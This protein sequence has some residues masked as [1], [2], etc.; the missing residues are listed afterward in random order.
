MKNQLPAHALILLIVCLLFPH[1]ALA[2]GPVTLDQLL[3]EADRNNPSLAAAQEQIAGAETKVAQVTSLADPVLSVALSNYPIDSLKSNQTPMTGNEIRLAQKFPFPGKL[4]AGGK[5]AAQRI[6]WYASAYQDARLQ[7]RQKV[8]DAWFRLL[9]LRQAI[10]LAQSN[11]G[12]IDDFIQ[13]TETRYQVGKGLQQNVLKANLQRSKQLDMLFALQQQEQATLG[14]INSLVGRGTAT[15]I[16]T[17]TE[18]KPQGVPF[19]LSQLQQQA[20]QKRPMFTA[21][22]AMIEEAKAKR[23]QARLGYKPDFTVWGSYRFRDDSL[24]DGGPD[25]LSAGVSFNLPV[26]RGRLDA[27]AAEADSALRLAYHKRDEFRNQ[28]NL[29]IHR[30]YTRLRQANDL[31][32]LYRTGII[33]QAEQ[34]LQATLSAYQV[35][36][37]DFLDLLDAEMTLYRYQTDHLRALADQQRSLAELQAAAGLEVDSLPAMPVPSSEG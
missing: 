1:L 20:V 5:A 10:G 11:L 9:F 31:A 35:D 28:V 18:L 33:P 2:E 15:P 29:S 34:T 27:A 23:E 13:L 24:P 30:A 16:E 22:A 12:I 26:R 7:L 17:R 19:E 21:F 32:E 36:K 4:A 37:V 8:K 3:S 6:R 25:F 14:E